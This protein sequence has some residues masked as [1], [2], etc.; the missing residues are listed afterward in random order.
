MSKAELLADA[1]SKLQPAISKSD[2]VAAYN[3]FKI[4]KNSMNEDSNDEET[5]TAYF[6]Y[7][8]IVRKLA[9]TT[10]WTEHSKKKS[11]MVTEEGVNINKYPK[12][13]LFMSK[14]KLKKQKFS[15]LKK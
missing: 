5:L 7:L 6:N 14:T 2:Y 12:L 8:L 1:H 4:W 13:H 15:L 11:M 9:P 3:K 10:V